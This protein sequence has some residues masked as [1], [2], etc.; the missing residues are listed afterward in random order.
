M[1]RII[2]KTANL[3]Q[4]EKI[5]EKLKEEAEALSLT[6]N[7]QELF[8]EKLACKKI[9][10][11]KEFVQHCNLVDLQRGL[12]LDLQENIKKGKEVLKNIQNKEKKA[13]KK[14]KE[15]SQDITIKEE[16]INKRLF[17]LNMS[18][19]NLLLKKEKVDTKFKITIK[20]EELKLAKLGILTEELKTGKSKLVK[21]S[22]ELKAIVGIEK[23][24][25][26]Y[27][28]SECECKIK[29]ID[30]INSKIE[31]ENKIS[32][33]I[34]SLIKKSKEQKILL[35]KEILGKKIV[36]EK[37]VNSTEKNKKELDELK[38]LTLQISKKEG[39]VKQLIIK[40]KKIYQQ[41]GINLN[42]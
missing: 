8:L 30:S 9:D 6:I 28:N 40:A 36:L 23:E 31:S 33:D 34:K 29:V 17:Y 24:R 21:E 25:L 3:K 15:F 2:Y 10:K 26:L 5:K 19:S 38:L 14:Y 16:R 4:E 41:A 42:V 12:L 32:E 20:G 18:Y 13:K 37:T 1:R 7:S 11:E 22:G 35:D 27:L 39:S